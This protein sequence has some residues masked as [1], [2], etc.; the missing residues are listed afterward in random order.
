MQESVSGRNLWELGNFTA[1]MFVKQVKQL[2]LDMFF[3]KI[4]F[5]SRLF[6]LNLTTG[7]CSEH[8]EAFVFFC[9]NPFIYCENIMFIPWFSV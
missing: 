6:W 3:K 9:F 7:T 8:M 4:T 1:T 5:Q 2:L